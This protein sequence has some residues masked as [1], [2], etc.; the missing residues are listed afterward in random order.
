MPPNATIKVTSD[1]VTGPEITWSLPSRRYLW[2]LVGLL[3]SATIFEGYDITIFHLCTPDIARTFALTDET[4]G[5]MATIVR[6]GGLLS[7]FVVSLADRYGRKPVISYTVLFYAFFTLMTALSHGV[8]SFT[9]FQGSA[10][11]FLAAEFGVA[12]TMITEEFPDDLR[13]RGISILHTVAFL[14]VATAGILYGKI[15]PTALGWRGLYFVGIAPMLLVALL[16]RKLRETA[17]FTAV[18]LARQAGQI[19]SGGVMEYFRNFTRPFS[20]AYRGRLILIAL[21]WNSIGLIGGPTITFFSLYAKRDHHWTSSQIGFA[22]VVAYLMAT[23]GTT[24]CGYLLD[25]V[26]RR[27]TAS[28]FYLLAAASMATLFH[29]DTHGL[30]L[31]SL[32]ATMFAY[33][34][35]RTATS[36]FSSELFPTGARATGYCMTVQ[37]LGQLGWTLAPLGVG[38]LSHPMGGL[39][40]AAALFAAGPVVGTILLLAFAPETRG[41]T[42]EELSPE[43]GLSNSSS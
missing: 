34:G 27:A 35:A 25:W 5:L 22:I 31:G 7:I 32:M 20:S 4:I 15:A 42:L 6:F 29:A 26:G 17:R 37:V 30:M 39:G 9:I 36:A 43:P 40:N 12:V 38:M 18:K 33:Q 16:R 10:Q 13:G 24:L 3:M 1:T 41:K 19:Y 11:I 28:L 21:L 23:V 2:A 8:V 14:G